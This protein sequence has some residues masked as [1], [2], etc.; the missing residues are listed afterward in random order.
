MGWDGGVRPTGAPSQVHTELSP[1]PGSDGP[2]GLMSTPHHL[3]REKGGILLAPFT[4]GSDPP[5]SRP[6]PWNAPPP[7]GRSLK[8]GSVPTG[9]CGWEQ[10]G[11]SGEWG[12]RRGGR[13]ACRAVSSSLP[14]PPLYP[15]GLAQPWALSPGVDPSHSGARLPGFESLLCHIEALYPQT[16]APTSLCPGLGGR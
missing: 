12:G 13:A 3:H 9:R 1:I 14:W 11:S 7:I 8:E 16:R 6:G 15:L 2:R 5:H 10:A 4:V